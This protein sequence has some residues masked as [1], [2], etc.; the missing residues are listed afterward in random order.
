MDF[1][2]SDAKSCFQAQMANINSWKIVVSLIQI[3]KY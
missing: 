3:D 1:W 2:F